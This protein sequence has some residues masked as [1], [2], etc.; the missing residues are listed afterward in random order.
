MDGEHYLPV[1]QAALENI[2]KSGGY[3]LLAIVFLGGTE[4]IVDSEEL[5]SLGYPVIVEDN[6]LTAVRRALEEYS[7]TGVIDLS[8]EPIVGYVERFRF[9][10]LVLSYGVSYIGADFRLDPPPFHEVMTKPSVSIIGTGKRVGKTALSAYVC[11]ELQGVGLKPCVV[12]M[13]RGGPPEPEVLPGEKVTLTPDYLLQASRE[14]KH[15]ASDYYE[16]ALMSRVTTIGCRRCGGGLAG[17]PF[18]SNVV[19]GAKLANQLDEKLVIFEGSGAALPPIRT[20]S[21]LVIVG[22]HQPVE[23][24]IGYLGTYRL[25]LSDL[26]VLTMCEPPLAD[27]TKVERIDEEIRRIKPGVKIVWTVFRPLP[28]K[29]IENRK[30]FLATTSSSA[31]GPKLKSYL[32]EK[33]N[34]EV[35]GISHHLSNRPLL[36]RDLKD[37]E[38]KFNVL[39]TELKAAS[40]DVATALGQ[41]MGVEVIYA[42]NVPVTV[43]GDGDLSSIVVEWAKQAMRVFSGEGAGH[44]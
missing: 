4:K 18:I 39:L 37:C 11:R 8:D 27:K 44:G 7:P 28:L 17:A 33:F 35:V 13:G 36:R 34:C 32:E 31:V 38:G 10:S 21:T 12:A 1:I 29:S 26:V 16:D 3:Q 9:A 2:E 5:D 19:A 40:V 14:G 42:D 20:N 6:S 25:L 43:G 41:K 15:A 24:I 22:A 23:Y 30:V